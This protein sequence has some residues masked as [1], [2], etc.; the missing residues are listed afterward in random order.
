MNATEERAAEYVLGTLSY[1]ERQT[2]QDD[3]ATNEQLR[4]AVAW[5]EEHLVSINNLTPAL[6]PHSRN[7]EAIKHR[8]GF[9]SKKSPVNWWRSWALVTS[10]ACL[11][12]VAIIVTDL[13]QTPDSEP[14]STLIVRNDAQEP[15][16]IIT[17]DWEKAALETEA[18]AVDAPGANKSYEL[19]LLTSA[20]QPPISLG[21]L[22]VAGIKQARL[23]QLQA[24]ITS[25]H[26]LA[27]S[28]EPEGGSP[29]GQPTGPVLY[30]AEFI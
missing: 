4:E 3:L 12:F 24:G 18:F 16:W 19:W 30:V 14:A 8:L 10:M 2:V 27:V 26:A 17:I 29:T 28:L 11:V 22:P 23:E 13:P 20:T 1:A 25:R 7:L 9:T 5:W 15:L 21:L 6:K